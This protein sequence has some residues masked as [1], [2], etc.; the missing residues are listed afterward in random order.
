MTNSC[1]IY[2]EISCDSEWLLFILIYRNSEKKHWKH[3]V[4]DRIPEAWN[5]K[6][7]GNSWFTVDWY[8]YVNKGA[9]GCQKS[10]Y[11]SQ[12]KTIGQRQINC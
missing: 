12:K 4:G 9:W 1:N 6:P 7:Q 8:W 3:T 10:K 11:E 2:V 5:N